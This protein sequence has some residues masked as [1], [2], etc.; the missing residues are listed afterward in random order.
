M[1]LA[2]ADFCP[3]I[4]GHPEVASLTRQETVIYSVMEHM[5]FEMGV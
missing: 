1:V 2:E 3:G 5:G 4:P